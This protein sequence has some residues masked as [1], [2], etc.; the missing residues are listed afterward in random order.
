M[1]I[2]RLIAL[3]AAMA[4]AWFAIY[5]FHHL[6]LDG[7]YPDWLLARYPSLAI[8]TSW[9]HSDV[10]TLGMWTGLVSALLFGLAIPIFAPTTTRR[11][12]SGPALWPVQ[13]SLLP[14]R[15]IILIATVATLFLLV[16]RPL[17]NVSGLLTTVIWLAVMVLL[18]AAAAEVEGARKVTL[19][20]NEEARPETGLRFL[21][22][23]LLMAAFLF[24][25]RNTTLPMTVPEFA[26][27]LGLQ[28]QSGSAILGTGFFA[29]GSAGVPRLSTLLTSLGVALAP[30]PFAGLA[31]P[32]LVAGLGTIAATWLLAAELFRRTPHVDHNGDGAEDD[33]RSP[34]LLAALTLAVLLPMIYFSRLP[35]L[36]EAVAWGTAG[37][38]LLLRAMRLG[39]L[40]SAVLSGLCIGLGATVWAGGLVL[41]GAAALL[42]LALITLQRGRL[43]PNLGGLGRRGAL[44]WL[45]ALGASASTSF[46]LWACGPQSILGSM[47]SAGGWRA[48]L[49]ATLSAFGL[50]FDLIATPTGTM[51]VFGLLLGPIFLLALGGLLFHLDTVIGWLLLG[52]LSLSLLAAAPGSADGTLDWNMLVTALPAAAIIVAFGLD[53]IRAT[54]ADTVGGWS[55]SAVTILA[56]GLLLVQGMQSW[57]TFP[58]VAGTVSAAP[59]TTDP[60]GVETSIL[61]RAAAAEPAASALALLVESPSSPDW[62]HPL[63]RFAT[64]GHTGPLTTLAVT[65]PATWPAAM[66]PG[67]VVL[68]LPRQAAGLAAL[69]AQYAGGS[70]RIE[71]DMRANPVLY[72]YTTP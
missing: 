14:S 69:R 1:K 47:L 35:V 52:W 51:L 46:C 67:T 50:S 63:L 16:A 43:A 42:W 65:A 11:V 44:L 66:P 26:A 72:L 18:F 19:L 53:R 21:I 6:S 61:A 22:P 57:R 17:L 40:R 39:S 31:W 15:L 2:L 62:S 71:R 36:L 41:A 48:G 13:R 49:L 4:L 32:A 60:V 37:L 23:I 5:L 59:Q 28:A 38:W 45:L 12:Q 30:N 34:A 54:L 9:L 56:A 70:L 10:L 64:T 58:A 20:A 8:T 29:L 3:L 25:W 68:V 27:A 33:G 55:A 7:F 24:A